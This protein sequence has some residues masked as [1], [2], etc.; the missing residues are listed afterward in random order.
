MQGGF[1]W[2]G[3]SASH[4]RGMHSNKIVAQQ[5]VRPEKIKRRSESNLGSLLGVTKFVEWTALD[6]NRRAFSERRFA[7]EWKRSQLSV[8][9]QTGPHL[10][11]DYHHHEQQIDSK[12]PHHELLR[13]F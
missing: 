9:M 7:R 2:I 5:F 13:P 6:G 4:V 12:R 8:L 1:D 10:V 11:Y 3:R